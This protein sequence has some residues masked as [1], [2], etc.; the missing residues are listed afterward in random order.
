[1]GDPSHRMTPGLRAIDLN[2]RVE[3][4][5]LE[6]ALADTP[7]HLFVPEQRRMRAYLDT[8]IPLGHGR[9]AMRPSVA[10]R[11]LDVARA[12]AA[13]RVLVMM[14]ADAYPAALAAAAGCDVTAVEP[15]EQLAAATAESLGRAGLADRVFV[16]HSL[17]AEDELFDAIVVLGAVER[18]PRAWLAHLAEDGVMVV[19][20]LRGG[21]ATVH[22]HLKTGRGSLRREAGDVDVPSLVGVPL[23]GA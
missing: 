6:M 21:S 19:P 3:Q 4:R 22:V 5:E 8:D 2:A 1:M 10:V 16:R 12:G 20:V 18:T 15:D 9:V 14:A 13:V 11:L 7:R 17:P 23:P